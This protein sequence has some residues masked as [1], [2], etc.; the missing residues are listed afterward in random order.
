MRG[1]QTHPAQGGHRPLQPVTGVYIC[2]YVYMYIC[3]KTPL[4]MVYMSIKPP[5]SIL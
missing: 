1:P 4:C 3:I 5:P 2:I